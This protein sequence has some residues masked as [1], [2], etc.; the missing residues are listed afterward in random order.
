MTPGVSVVREG[1]R[2]WKV[3]NRDFLSNTYICTTAN[4]GQCF[5][6]DPGLD[7]EV[8]DAALEKLALE[9]RFVFCTHGHFDH[10][11]SA[12]YFQQKYAARVFLH[13]NDVRTMKAS[14]FLLMAFGLPQRIE[15]PVLEP[16]V[17]DGFTLVVD[18]ETLRYHATA[19]HTP[20]SCM[21]EIGGAVYSGDSLYSRGLGLSRLPGEDASQ[22]RASLR[23]VRDRFPREAMTYP[24]HGDSA[25]WGWIW[26]NNRALLEFVGSRGDCEGEVAQ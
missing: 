12:A 2:I 6:V 4:A 10:V 20:G 19:G 9:P 22:L 25:A 21:L 7:A 1:V 16:A 26:E 3:V 24:G 14:N 15:L 13:P 8:I 5:L 11:G 23:A 17:T 18:G